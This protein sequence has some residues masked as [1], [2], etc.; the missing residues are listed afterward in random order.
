M[1]VPNYTDSGS[2]LS[3]PVCFQR[4][5]RVYR[6]CEGT[7]WAGGLCATPRAETRR[8]TPVCGDGPSAA[9]GRR[10][11]GL[12][13]FSHPPAWAGRAGAAAWRREAG[14]RHVPHRGTA[15]RPRSAAQT[16]SRQATPPSQRQNRPLP[17]C[18]RG[19]R[20]H[21]APPAPA[22]PVAVPRPDRAP[23]VAE[24]RV[25]APAEP[26]QRG[27]F[28]RSGGAAGAGSPAALLAGA[29]GAPRSA[30]RA[31]PPLSAWETAG[32]GGSVL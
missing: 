25:V 2:N 11:A 16:R 13:R 24:G 32:S 27:A 17:R 3:V 12:Q 18:C 29:G 22:R 21:G 9:Q 23:A 26:P 14:V 10:S 6:R 15:E 20:A 7:G 5:R 31:L 1:F 30:P 19:P 28:V 8:V 4:F